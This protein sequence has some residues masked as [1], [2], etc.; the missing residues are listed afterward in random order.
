MD[1]SVTQIVPLQLNR[2]EHLT[3]ESSLLKQAA[4]LPLDNRVHSEFK[5]EEGAEIIS[6]DKRVRNI[7]S[8]V[9]GP[10]VH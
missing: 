8:S 9:F 5:D 4:S 1:Q 10:L 3:P 7:G 2:E 6:A